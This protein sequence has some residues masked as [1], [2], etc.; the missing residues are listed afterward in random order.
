MDK[1]RRINIHE[2]EEVVECN[3]DRLFPSNDVL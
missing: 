3:T 1:C 2:W